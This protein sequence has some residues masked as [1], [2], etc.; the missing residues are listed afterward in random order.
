MYY[1]SLV[2]AVQS[3]LCNLE[4]LKDDNLS[5]I[6]N[7]IL[8][9]KLKL[10]LK[11][12]RGCK[13]MYDLINTKSITPKSQIKYTNQGFSFTQSDWEQY[14]MLPFQCVKDSTLLWFQYRLVQRILATN[15][16]L[17]MIHYVDSNRCS[18]CNNYPETILHLFFECNET[19]QLWDA[20][21]DWILTRTGN[22]I[23]FSKTNIMF[24]LIN[25]EKDNFLNWL[26]I[27][28]KYYVYCTKI[29]KKTLEILAIKNVLQ[30][31]FHIEKYILLKSCNYEKYNKEWA[32]WLNLFN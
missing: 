17:H 25:N 10:L 18:L 20:V 22:T 23:N 1:A 2:E 13:D 14:Y 3:C 12:Q 21:H 24:G 28:I 27:N 30:T 11:S 7:P 6:C 29:Q 5:T 19:K 15:S 31:K 8:P 32:P 26:I 9:L 16:F 4:A